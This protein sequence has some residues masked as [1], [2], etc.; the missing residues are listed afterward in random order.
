MCHTVTLIE[1][2]RTKI[3]LIR[4]LERPAG[5]RL[6]LLAT[7]TDK[8]Q[9]WDHGMQSFWNTL[10]DYDFFTHQP[11]L[12]LLKINWEAMREKKPFRIGKRQKTWQSQ[13]FYLIKCIVCLF[14]IHIKI[15][16]TRES[17]T[18]FHLQGTQ[19]KPRPHKWALAPLPSSEAQYAYPALTPKTHNNCTDTQLLYEVLPNICI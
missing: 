8:A 2:S 3:S 9:Q 12:T 19:V 6:A 4:K 10:T 7:V 5:G 17:I 18:V 11:P 15:T 1:T 13:S 16:I 14:Q